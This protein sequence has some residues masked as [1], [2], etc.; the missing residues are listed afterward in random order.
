ML[1]KP[2]NVRPRVRGEELYS[3]GLALPPRTLSWVLALA[4]LPPDPPP[5]PTFSDEGLPLASATCFQGPG[6]VPPPRAGLAPSPA[7]VSLC[8]T[9]G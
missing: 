5:K 3:R 4:F 6:A 7:P 2:L 1:P 9:K 8:G